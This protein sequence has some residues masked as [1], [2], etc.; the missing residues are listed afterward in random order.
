MGEISQ[1]N[2]VAG[3]VLLLGE[4]PLVTG[5]LA[6]KGSL[7]LSNPGIVGFTTEHGAKH[8]LVGKAGDVR[9]EVKGLYR[10]GSLE[11]GTLLRIGGEEGRA[12]LGGDVAGDGPRLVDDE[13]VVVL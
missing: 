1:S 7:E 3:E 13:A 10:G 4:D 6:L 9:V 8:K 12:G 2:L 5:E 11:E